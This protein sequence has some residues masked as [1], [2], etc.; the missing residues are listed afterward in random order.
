MEIYIIIVF[1]V[2]NLVLL[3][4]NIVFTTK[5]DNGNGSFQEQSEKIKE[6]FELGQ[7]GVIERLGTQSTTVTEMVRQSVELLGKNIENEQKNLKESTSLTLKNI[8]DDFDGMRKENKDGL[9][10]IRLIVTEKMQTVLSDRLGNMSSNITRSITDLG[11]SL[12]EEQKNQFNLIAQS[13]D[14]LRQE[15]MQS[16][17]KINGTVNEKLQE[18]LD[19]RISESFKTVSEQLMSVSKGLGEM[20]SV[21]E[22]VSDLRKVLSNVKSRGVFG[23]V[24]LEAILEEILTPEQYE[25]QA[26][27]TG[28]GDTRVDFAVK[29]PGNGRGEPVYLPIDA[30][31]PGDTFISLVEALNSGDANEANERRKKLRA[32]IREEA[33]SIRSKYIAP[34]K[35]TDFAI[36]FLPSEGLYSE[37]VNMGMIEELQHDYRVNIAGPS[38]MSALLNSL[39]MGFQT[40]RIQQKSTEIQKILEAAKKEFQNFE[41]S[42]EGVQKRLKQTEEELS[43][44]VGVRTRAINKALKDITESDTLEIA[45]EVIGSDQ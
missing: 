28:V 34:P 16:L 24:Q 38:T 23:E 7:K 4:V 13:M 35:T 15:N 25:V 41:S 39:R 27:V 36:M 33:K 37:V 30:K 43:K 44:L 6:Y 21:A 22:N 20:Q 10:E 40:L 2:I 1:S 3:I 14:K 26:N 17:E 42:L 12:R 18:S 11:S 9:S 8:S 31:F 5:R 32:T 29:L 45:Q 19:K